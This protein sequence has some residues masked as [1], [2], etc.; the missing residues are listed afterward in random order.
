MVLENPK[1]KETLTEELPDSWWFRVYV[2]VIATTVV[3]VILL[4]VFTQIFS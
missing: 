3:V 1:H 2:G 4:W